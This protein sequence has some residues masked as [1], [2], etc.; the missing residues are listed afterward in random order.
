[1]GWG[2]G[3]NRFLALVGPSGSGKSSVIKAGLI[4]ALRDGA[5]PGS[6]DWFI[7]E[8]TP[9]SYP[10]EELEAALLRV[11][12]NPPPSL[13]EP[14]QKDE[15]GLVRV[16]KRLLPQD[17]D[18]ENPSQLLLVIDQFEELFTLV[19]E[20]SDRAHFL[21]NLFAALTEAHARLWVI[22]TLRADF[23]DR[24]L[25]NPQLGEWLR[26]RTE[27]VLPMSTA[28][29]EEAIAAPA[30]SMGVTLEPGL[31]S[32]IL[33]DVKEQPGALPLMQY[34]LTELFERRNGRSLTLVAYKEIGGVTGALARRA[35]EIYNG[36]DPEGQADTRQLF[37]RLV[38]LGEGVED[39]R[40]RVRFAELEGLTVNG[41]PLSV[42]RKPLSE[43]RSPITDYG[44]YRLLTFDHDPGTREPTVEVAHEALLREWQRL[45]DWLAESR[46]DVRMQRLLA[47]EA[48]GWQTAEDASYLLR[49]ARLAQ[50][51]G[52]VSH[53]SIAL[54]QGERA[55]LQASVEAREER[56]AQEEARRQ[57]ELETVQ[58]LA[59]TERQ[60]AEE[61]AQAAGRLRQRAV[62]LGM[63]AVVAVL[64]AVAAFGF[65][66]QSQ[67]N[68]D[69]AATRES[70]A[71]ANAE[72]AVTR[73][74]EAVTEANQRAT[75]QAETEL[76]RERADEERDTAVTEAEQRA[77]AE[78]NAQENQAF[79]EQQ[80]A[81]TQEQLRLTTS[82]ELALAANANLESN[83][84]R[85]LLLGLTALDNA[86]TTEAEE[87]VRAALQAS[88]VD[89]TL[90]EEGEDIW[91]IDY[92]PDGD[93]LA[94][95]GESGIV[96]WD[97]NNGDRL[98]TIP[99]DIIDNRGSGGLDIS[100]DGSLLAVT[101]QNEILILDTNSWEVI[102][103]LVGHTDIVDAIDFNP[104]STLLAS[105]SIDSEL[106]IWDLRSGEVQIS[107]L[108][109]DVGYVDDVDFSRDGSRI[110]TGGDDV[111]ARIWDVNTGGELLRMGHDAL[112]VG[113]IAF[114]ADDTRLFTVPAVSSNGSQVAV[115]NIAANQEGELIAPIAEW[116][117]MHDG[118]ISDLKLSPD[119]RLLVTISQDGTAKLW[120]ATSDT[121]VEILTLRGHLS[122]VEDVAFSPNSPKIATIS[123]GVV[124]IWDITAVGSGEILNIADSSDPIG[125]S[126]DGKLLYTISRTRSRSNDS[127]VKIWDA[128]TGELKGTFDSLVPN[129]KSFASSPD[130]RYLAVGGDDN[131]VK[132]WD[133][134]TQQEVFS[135]TE[136]GPGI[137]GAVHTG[138]LGLKFSP[139]GTRLAT[140]GADGYVMVWEVGS[141]D[142][143]YEWRAD[144][145]NQ[146]WT[147]YEAYAN[148]V[149]RVMF[150]PGSRFLAASTDQA[151]DNGRG[152]IKIWDL[153][154][155]EEMIVIEDIPGRITSLAFSP[156]SKHI[157]SAAGSGGG[158]TIWDVASGNEV[159]F[160]EGP[161]V[162]VWG[163]LFSPD[164][165]QLIAILDNVVVFDLESEEV[166]LQLP[167]ALDFP[168]LSPDGRH[169]AA[170]GDNRV[171]IYTLDFEELLAIAQARV[172]RGLAEAECKQYLHL[173]SCPVGE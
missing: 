68:A 37:L 16:L 25:Q 42:I 72:L 11:A 165:R 166:I 130:G 107:V 27:L 6:E 34:A 71:V 153:T 171:Q 55:F 85:S 67:Q 135:V 92:H 83:P 136:H 97:T 88:R 43:Y 20:E 145:R 103:T 51:E 10:L 142:K 86:Y 98:Q 24:P 128:V 93:W 108:A 39:T 7:V 140:G 149:T 60:R 59:E 133:L 150:D 35:D 82:R 75:A 89:L 160:L 56:Q 111:T 131:V 137:I 96:I 58:Q 102:H 120:D 87:V 169:I 168:S 21:D 80:Q 19:Q 170:S 45:R 138:V 73:E 116:F 161:T 113:D 52:W 119:G 101:S 64:L 115:W 40:R 46:Q 22:V 5:L 95:V 30:A 154:T 50:F 121:A 129:V 159:A 110:A 48:R 157:A 62:Y 31:V 81:L 99:L 126:P 104:D 109:S 17:R 143:L 9:G 148:G 146:I 78:A 23:Y 112:W 76:E 134:S 147:G 36:L 123:A 47:N 26:Q 2:G 4:P 38:T 28:E 84:E 162:A 125:Y 70:E 3:Q 152:L 49:G 15:R 44:N 66:R 106:K 53:S 167:Q 29:L 124:Q 132:I 139:D 164:G 141:W 79:A 91:W 114:N 90:T 8:M 54:T 158:G 163:V 69:L 77:T 13:L 127:T 61:Q 155:G 1:V 18:V 151:G 94:G 100:P 105:G 57:R 118:L 14:L 63:A 41:Y 156:D 74:A 32:A 172:T 12:V 65:S 122:T 117:D 173:D 144:P 33:T